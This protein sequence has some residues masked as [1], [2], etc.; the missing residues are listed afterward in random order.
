MPIARLTILFEDTFWTGL[1]ERECGGTY[2]A[3]KITFGAEP[4]GPA[5]HGT[6]GDRHKGAAGPSG[7]ARGRG[8]AEKGDEPRAA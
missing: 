4:R 1:Y 6:D 5:G 2:E 8:R 3:A 7:P